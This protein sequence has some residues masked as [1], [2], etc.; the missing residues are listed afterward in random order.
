M[1]EQTTNVEQTQE[2]PSLL[3][4]EETV[5]EV[6]TEAVTDTVDD[7]SPTVPNNVDEYDF[8]FQDETKWSQEEF[9]EF[10]EQALSLGIN[11]EQFNNIMGLYEERVSTMLDSF[12]QTP[13]KATDTLQERWGDN[14]D[15]NM[16]LAQKAFNQ[17]V[18]PEYDERIGNNPDVIEILAHIGRQLQEDKGPPSNS[19]AVK[20]S[21]YTKLEIEEFMKAP[22]YWNN[23]EK[24]RIV[25]AWYESH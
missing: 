5:S 15:S 4:R 2:Q 12:V 8:K 22:D 1:D 17:L 9:Q 11:N 13:E 23:K 19:N 16:K 24:Q 6:S 14:F 7:T 10:K 3:Q 18:P 20:S 25:S 21:G